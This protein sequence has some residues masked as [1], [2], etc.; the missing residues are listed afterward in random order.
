MIRRTIVRNV[1]DAIDRDGHDED[2][3]PMERDAFVPTQLYAMNSPH[4]L[5]N[6][7]Y[8]TNPKVVEQSKLPALSDEQP[9]PV[10]FNGATL[11]WHTLDAALNDTPDEPVSTRR[12]NTNLSSGMS[13]RSDVL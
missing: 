11:A 2:F 10:R 3:V 12:V 5:L 6:N 7:P 8:P 13:G 9:F 4:L 1:F